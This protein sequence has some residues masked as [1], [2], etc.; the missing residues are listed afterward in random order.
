MTDIAPCPCG[1]R[2]P[3]VGVI[4][5]QRTPHNQTYMVCCIR[6]GRVGLFSGTPRG[7]IENWNQDKLYYQEEDN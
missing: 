4:R 1:A 2:P 3:T 5:R 6:C 7:A